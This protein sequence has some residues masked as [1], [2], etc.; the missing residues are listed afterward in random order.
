MNRLLF[1]Y[2][3][4]DTLNGRGKIL[5]ASFIK[6]IFCFIYWLSWSDGLLEMMDLWIRL[7]ILLNPCMKN[8]LLFQ[9]FSWYITT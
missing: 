7:Y 3:F 1:K 5:M 9:C 8:R 6:R 2:L 4:L